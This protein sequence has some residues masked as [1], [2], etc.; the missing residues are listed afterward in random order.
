MYVE[1]RIHNTHAC[2]CGCARANAYA[3]LSMCICISMNIHIYLLF[4]NTCTHIHIYIYIYIYI[5]TC[6][7]HPRL[8]THPPPPFPGKPRV[9]PWRSL[10]PR[11]SPAS[12]YL[13]S[14]PGW[15]GRSGLFVKPLGHDFTD[16]LPDCC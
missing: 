1:L 7:W 15:G 9:P 11:P 5:C 2:A 13:A 6:A 16:F 8:K 14:T 3:H 4:L 12:S 10:E